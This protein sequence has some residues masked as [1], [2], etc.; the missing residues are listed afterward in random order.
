MSGA[1]PKTLAELMSHWAA[2]DV[3]SL[4]SSARRDPREKARLLVGGNGRIRGCGD[5]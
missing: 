3:K 5:R 2:L 1:M 4:I